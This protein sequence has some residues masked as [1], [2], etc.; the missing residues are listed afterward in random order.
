MTRDTSHD[1]PAGG[2]SHS[3]PVIPLRILS[4]TERSLRSEAFNT[5]VYIRSMPH[6]PVAWVGSIF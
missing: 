1:S 5:V 3:A 6:G 2:L 4:T